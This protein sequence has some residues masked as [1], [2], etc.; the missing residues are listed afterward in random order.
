M[1]SLSSMIRTLCQFQLFVNCVYCRCAECKSS[2]VHGNVD[3]TDI[4]IEG[5]EYDRLLRLADRSGLAKPTDLCFSLCAFFYAYY[6]YLFSAEDLFLK[7]MRCKNQQ[8]VF[9]SAIE[10][11]MADNP[12]SKSNCGFPHKHDFFR[13]YR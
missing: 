3:V 9:V 6:D 7:L 4:S 5:V 8:Q 13:N 10:S 12:V 2:L 1:Y 11:K